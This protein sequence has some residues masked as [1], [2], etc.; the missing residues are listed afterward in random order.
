MWFNHLYVCVNDFLVL[1]ISHSFPDESKYH[2][3]KIN[4]LDLSYNF[5][6]IQQVLVR[7]DS[8]LLSCV[9]VLSVDRLLFARYET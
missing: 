1:L 9:F 3:V 8:N 4:V 2:R 6:V 7:V 5:D